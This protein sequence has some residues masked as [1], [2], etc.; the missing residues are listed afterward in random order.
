MAGDWIPIS[1]NLHGKPEVARLSA[2]LGQSIDTT[3]GQLVRF[4][5][6][7]QAHTADGFLQGL[8]LEN[9]ALAAQVS[10]EFLAELENVGWLTVTDKGVTIPNFDRW[11][12]GAAKRRI[13]ANERITQWRIRQKKQ[14][15]DTSDPGNGK[16]VTPDALH[17]C[18]RRARSCNASRVTKA[19]QDEAQCAQPCNASDVIESVTREE[20]RREENN[21][22]LPTYVGTQLASQ[23]AP[24]T[25]GVED[26]QSD[27]SAP[28]IGEIIDLITTRWNAIKGVQPIR[29]WSEKRKT[30][31]RARLKN[32]DW[33]DHA[34]EA[35]KQ[36][37]KCKFLLGHNE[38]KWRASIDWFLRP[39]SIL[40]ILEGG[41]RGGKSPNDSPF[42]F[43]DEEES[44]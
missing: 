40:R 13:A 17:K 44:S 25:E 5:C 15:N 2:A 24:L 18:T 7:S 37:P 39:D 32:N 12:S 22:L 30:H 19:L 35:L 34:L 3:V 38:E 33:L 36:L 16:V 6:W 4:W 27:V 31:L 14:S 9:C 26:S 23:E 41:Y 1:V 10:I 42:V 28:K 21:I 20:N 11:F 29:F 43:S 8:T